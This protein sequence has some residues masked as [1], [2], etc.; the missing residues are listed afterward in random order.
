MI[1]P[2]A[3]TEE[4]M[5]ALRQPAIDKFREERLKEDPAR[6]GQHF[7]ARQ[8]DVEELLERLVNMADL[9]ALGDDTIIGVLSDERLLDATRY[10]A[11]PPVSADDLKTLAEVESLSPKAIKAD[12]ER[13][14][15]IFQ[16]V[17]QGI[18]RRRFPWVSQKREPTEAERN[19]AVVAS[20][21]LM[22]TTRL[23]TDRRNEGK[24][25]QETAVKAALKSI[26]FTLVAARKIQT[27]DDAPEPGEFC[28]ESLLGGRKA[29]IIVRL[30][31]RRVLAIECKVSNS[32]IN[33]IKRL[34]NDAAAKAE[35]WLK[36]FGTKQLI[37]SAMLSGVFDVKNLM[38]SQARGLTLW[39]AHA[40][41]D[42]LGW[43]KTAA[44]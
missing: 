13:S 1:A 33:S 7:D 9:D 17:L 39:W 21:A 2:P 11:G 22:A 28:G 43:I 37:P 41:T 27:L 31:D 18:D 3:W 25:E 8:G 12:R 35:V 15:R 40:M 26:G 38:D 20:A 30:H 44:S 29:D 24:D 19:A 6:Y 16:T 34:R 14:R 10:L 23:S 32:E 4:Q 5:V 42:F 36:E